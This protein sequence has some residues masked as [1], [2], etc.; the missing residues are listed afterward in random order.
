MFVDFFIKRPIFATVCALLIILGG[1]VSIPTLP[2]AQFP[3]LA[4]P[5]VQV[6]AFYNG[7]S[8]QVVETSVT[9]PLEQQIN[10]VEGM[11]YMTSTSGN[12]GTSG[13][14]VIFDLNR[15]VDLAAVD[16]QNRVNQA[17]GR[18]PNEVKTTG[19]SVVKAT[20]NFVFGAG[21]YA[22]GNRYDS[23]F[24]SNYLDIYV[25]DALKRIRGVGDVIIFG[26]RKYAMRLWPD[27]VR[28][29]TRQLTASDVVT[30]LQEQNVQVAAGAVGQA[31]APPN[32]QYEISVRAVGRLTD[33]AQFDNIVLKTAPDGT[34][35]RLKDVGHA[36]LGAENYDSGLRFNG[37]PAVGVGVTQLSNANAIEVDRSAIA[38]L[39]RLSK[40]FPPGLKFN[41]AFDTTDVVA[42]SIRDVIT[43]LIEAILL[44]IFVI[45]LFLQDWRSTVIP[46]VTIPVSLVGTFIFVKALGFSINTLT[47]FGITLAT[48]LVVDDAIVVIE[49][50]Q[51]HISEGVTEPHHAASV[52]MSE[53]AG[54]V[55]ATSLVLVSVFVPVAFFPGT[56]GIMFRQFALTIAFSVAISAFNAL[57]LTPA[58]SALML[59]HH[60][61]ESDRGIF[62]LFN[63]GV[64]KVT[65]AYRD[66]LKHLVPLRWVV[67]LVFLAGLGFTYWFYQRV[68]RGFVPQEDQGYFMILVQCPPGASIEYTE[69]IAKQVEQV[70]SREKDIIGTFA[71]SGFSFAG[72][73]P[74]R[75]MV[76]GTL[77]PMSQRKGDE[78]SAEA[79]INRLRG[80]L[81]GISGA[82]V[83]PFAPPSVNGLGNFG[84]FQY[85]L[86]DEGGHTP[87]EL[88]KVAY[89]LIG[90]G[91][92]PDSGLTG[93]FTSYSATDPQFLV[94]IDR[95]KAK[96]LGVS[97][98]QIT[99]TL[100]VYMAS[101]YVN[102]FDFNNRAYR[103]YIQADQQARMSPQSM[104]Q[105][106][107]RSD[108]GGMVPLE[109]LVN[110]TQTTTPPVI[111]H[112][113]LFRSVELDGSAARGQSS[114]QAIAKMQELSAKI[115]PH[116]YS[117]AWTGLSLEEIE[118]G[119]QVVLLFAL[120][121]LVVYLTLAAQ[122]ESWSLPF[123]VILAVPMAILGAVLAQSL[124]GLINDIYC[125][126]GLVMLI[127]L[128][129][130][131]AILIV[132]FAEQLRERGLSI[133]EAALEAARIRLR[134][135][136]MTS[137]AFMLGVLPLVLASGAGKNGRQSVGT[138]AS[139]GM[140]A[141]TTLN[142]LFIPILYVTLKTLQERWGTG[143]PRQIEERPTE[144]ERIA[145]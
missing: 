10:G 88:G 47:L 123:I 49:N 17:L 62:G 109:D 78:R 55:V 61:G 45:F 144:D 137:L 140:L 77:A 27:P 142:L 83:V 26:E 20:N 29:A 57:T 63:R 41:V 1:A 30:A 98:S 56:T 130:K 33:P 11:K 90:A 118:S 4:P 133:T 72:A 126:V 52:A 99:N 59:G 18:M 25:R 36:E 67:V 94:S 73:A 79:I 106:Y 122:Y 37:H 69:N 35:V 97:L 114:G 39:E 145:V 24:I 128:S 93:L 46:A 68:P 96:S 13:I 119:S 110:I 108:K 89:S 112:Y 124:R 136:L 71:V 38:E 58:L 92:Q 85:I 74:N 139:G 82:I 75:G 84:G 102:D 116:G 105:F 7:A 121:L 87:E 66:T 65:H 138:T 14:S 22:E 80:P 117:Y 3:N 60:T 6:S 43:T 100:Q 95:E 91:N 120:G 32:Q 53:V 125:Q 48:G 42:D 9:T 86:Q 135:I 31:P 127:G 44:V 50:V 40:S 34:I 54:A 8:A 19:V 16:V 131:N 134:P 101:A 15:D 103:V 2:V 129:S 64:H 143:T 113:N 23:L 111:S 81:F 115:L 21:F 141:A 28:M 107:V 12:D 104:K 51:R 132:E 76:F 5:T 70:M